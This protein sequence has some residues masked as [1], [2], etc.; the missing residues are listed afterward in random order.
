MEECVSS[1]TQAQNLSRIQA[2][3]DRTRKIEEHRKNALFSVFERHKKP[4]LSFLE[5]FL[6]MFR[7]RDNENTTNSKTAINSLVSKEF[8]VF[9]KKTF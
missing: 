2:L 8:V 9:K 4:Q 6:S 3:K 7:L 1:S 5:H